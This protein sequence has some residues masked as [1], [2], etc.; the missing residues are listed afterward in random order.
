MTTPTKPPP[1]DSARNLAVF[2]AVLT[3]VLVATQSRDAIVLFLLDGWLAVVVSAVATLAAMLLVPVAT[4]LRWRILVG[5][6][7]GHGALSLLILTCG[8]S[9]LLDR[10]LWIIALLAATT[11]A[12]FSLWKTARAHPGDPTESDHRTRWLW[13]WIAPFAALTILVCVVPP[14]FLWIEE[15]AGYDVLEY[16]LQLPREYFES[17][18]IAYTPHN[19]YGNFPANTEM[20]YLLSMIL[21]DDPF[22]GAATAKVFNA[23]LG[24]W[25]VFAAWVAGE[26]ARKGAGTPTAVLAACSGWLVY[27]SGIAYVE[28]AMLFYLM[29]A[30]ALAVRYINT[31]SWTWLA[32][33]GLC[34]GFACGCKYT[35]IILG[36]LPFAIGL[37]LDALRRP[38]GETTSPAKRSACLTVVVFILPCVASMSP[39]L[40]KNSLLTGNPVFPLANKVF[41]AYPEGFG[42]AE[43]RHFD[44]SH[45]SDEALKG[46][47][48][49]L[50][51]LWTSIPADPLQRVGPAVLLLAICG[52]PSFR[53]NR[54]A[55]FM[56][57]VLLTQLAAWAML[58]HL[59]ARFTVPILIPLTLLAGIAYRNRWPHALLLSGGLAINLFCIADYWTKH[60]YHE[61]RKLPIEGAYPFFRDGLGGSYEHLAVINHELPPDAR[62]LSVGDARAFYF[63]K[64]NDYCVVFNRSPFEAVAESAKNPAEIIEWLIQEQYTHVFVN[65]WEIGRLRASS[66]G[67]PNV[68]DPNLFKRLE[69]AGLQRTH[70][71]TTGQPL[72]PYGSLYAV[73]G[74]A[75]SGP[76]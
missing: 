19:V 56:A 50:R 32:L 10:R 25:F 7:I 12:T 2:V 51:A 57:V 33:S 44:A 1:A 54:V 4:P 67:F 26:Q 53:R 5:A 47:G 60:T 41:H 74:T 31:R 38:I 21:R 28:N 29:S 11:A 6:A 36:A 20:L 24:M 66:Y 69:I 52:I 58:T 72:R 39:W 23:L 35:A 68:I 34:A 17:G 3:V 42:L 15:G 75:G 64:P 71:F 9:S 46:I 45:R 63:E 37:F 30:A 55:L 49:R 73:P 14:G 27:L 18:R 8:F 61:G 40:I 22:N 16:H 59:Y 65:W 43:S 13:W 70:T 62:I 76:K 48:G